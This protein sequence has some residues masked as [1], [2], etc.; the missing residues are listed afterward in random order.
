MTMAS[1]TT[2]MNSES[3]ADR[4]SA[5]VTLIGVQIIVAQ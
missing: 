4:P 2:L 3:S 5:H 1:K